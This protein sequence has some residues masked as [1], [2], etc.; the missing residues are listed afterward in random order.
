MLANDEGS[1]WYNKAEEV[2]LFGKEE[3]AIA[4]WQIS[5]HGLTN[6]F[7][8]EFL[9]NGIECCDGWVWFIY[10]FIYESTF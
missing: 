3:T 9:L 5:M 7:V 8:A 2:I 4:C 6:N 10:L 1:T